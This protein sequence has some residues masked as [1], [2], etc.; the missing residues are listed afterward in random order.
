[1]RPR[2]N[3]LVLTWAITWCV[4]LEWGPWKACE[5]GLRGFDKDTWT[6][7]IGW[8]QQRFFFYLF[9]LFF[10][11]LIFL[12]ILLFL[13]IKMSEFADDNIF[14]G[15]AI[16]GRLFGSGIGIVLDTWKR[17]VCQGYRLLL[18]LFYFIFFHFLGLNNV[19][20]ILFFFSFGKL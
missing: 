19:F 1:M 18:C 4:S 12:F 7:K 17:G 3:D 8:W 20:C 5:I 15:R 6:A 14:F 11:W 13:V 9:F 16:D 2:W 10:G